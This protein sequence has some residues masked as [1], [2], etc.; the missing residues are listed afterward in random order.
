MKMDILQE[1]K[2]NSGILS[3]FAKIFSSGISLSHLIISFAIIAIAAY[4]FGYDLL[5]NSLA[6]NDALSALS[7]ITYLD[8]YFPK[9]PL[10]YPYQGGGV[11][12]T[13]GYPQLYSYVVIL[14]K[15][16]L[17]LT[18]ASSMGVVNFAAVL[19]PAWGVYL[20][21]ANRLKSKTG[22]L[23]AGLF[24]LLSP[25][26]YVWIWGA[27]FLAQTF[28]VIFV[29]FFLIFYDWFLDSSLKGRINPFI[30]LLSSF[31]GA[32][33]FLSHPATGMG[34]LAFSG[35]YT[36]GRIFLD[37]EGKSKEKFVRGL[38][39][40]IISSLAILGLV[41]F[42]FIPLQGYS[43][44]ANRGLKTSLD[45]SIFAPFE[46]KGTL[47]LYDLKRYPWGDL[48]IFSPIWILALVGAALGFFYNRKTTILG[49]LAIA[50][51][52]FSD[53]RA[54]SL[55]GKI[56]IFLATF[57]TLRPWYPLAVVLN[58]IAAGMG[59]FLI[60]RLILTPLYLVGLNKLNAVL[61]F[62]IDSFRKI[63]HSLTTIF[64]A[65][66]AFYLLMP[67]SGFYDSATPWI[68]PI[69]MTVG[70][71][72]F[73]GVWN[74][75]HEERCELKDPENHKFSQ[76]CNLPYYNKY[77]EMSTLFALCDRYPRDKELPIICGGRLDDKYLD[78]KDLVNYINQN[79]SEKEKKYPY[80]YPNYSICLALGRTLKEQLLRWP[81]PELTFG[82]DDFSS[83]GNKLNVPPEKAE[84]LYGETHRVD[85][86][87]HLGTAVKAWT[88]TNR[89]YILN[90]YTGQLTLNKTFFSIFNDSFYDNPNT[91]PE[92]LNN[93]AKYFGIEAAVVIASK[94]PMESFVKG[95]WERIGT[96][97]AV[98]FPPFK[99]GLVSLGELPKILVIGSHDK[100]VFKQAFQ[101]ATSGAIPFDEGIVIDG[102]ESIRG[103]SLKELSKYSLVVLQG[104]KY[105]NRARDLTTLKEYINQGGTVFI[106]TG[107]Q[108]VSSDWG[109]RGNKDNNYQIDLPEPFPVTETKWGGIGK[110]WSN[111][112]LDS[113]FSNDVQLAKFA[114]LIWENFDWS[115]SYSDQLRSWAKPILGKAG[116]IVMAY[117]QIGKGKIVWSGMNIFAHSLD[118]KNPEEIKLLENVFEYLLPSQNSSSQDGFSISSPQPE[119][120]IVNL[121][122]KVE[123]GES[124]YFR[125]NYYPSWQARAISNGKI[126]PLEIQVAGPSFMLASLPA[127]NQGDKVEFEFRPPLEVYIGMVLSLITLVTLG[128]FLADAVFLRGYLYEKFSLLATNTSNIVLKPFRRYIGEN[129]KDLRDEE[130]EY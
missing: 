68:L 116:K 16:L 15:R 90:A 78:D 36:M 121:G 49:I 130:N 70:G 115:L 92:V 57:F 32:L 86:T 1:K 23:L 31:F 118:K 26:T 55:I 82:Q 3:F 13:L 35:L 65:V 111:A 108:Y 89:S 100:G 11:S 91:P 37:K 2:R 7:Y 67:I 8:K 10:W 29:P 43:S 101:V 50:G 87:P 99:T 120:V 9:I 107:W 38:T 34:I 45:T 19:L 30:L 47:G 129:E 127:L 123:E 81:L 58:P 66:L 25:M 84:I 20:F 85:V 113:Q 14:L 24:F 21:V 97:A 61:R 64:V 104:Y 80:F 52:F 124:V 28:S 74:G 33:A 41:A 128:I 103:Y 106:D 54:F 6:G 88:V 114:P 83:M 125:E 71:E 46:F 63:V 5:S 79:C 44:F 95:G 56:W 27:G 62:F 93:L 60:A 69:G 102:G 73:R 17:G 117:G 48:S 119:K 75:T 42:W 39:T 112:S 126:Y 96:E 122:K 110:D 76:L 4:F 94:S 51:L 72:D 109:D 105:G 12:A 18:Y 59:V 22:G 77:F 53:I 40:L 98:V